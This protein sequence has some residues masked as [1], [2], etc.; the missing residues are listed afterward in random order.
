MHHTFV[1]AL[2]TPVWKP[3][4]PRSA[5][6]TT[7]HRLTELPLVGLPGA[8][9][10]W[11]D[12]SI[13][14]NSTHQWAVVSARAVSRQQRS[15]LEAGCLAGRPA[16]RASG[17]E[18]PRVSR[19]TGQKACHHACG[20]DACALRVPAGRCKAGVLLQCEPRNASGVR[21]DFATGC[22]ARSVQDSNRGVRSGVNLIAWRAE[23]AG[24]LSRMYRAWHACNSWRL[25]TLPRRSALHALWPS[26]NVRPVISH[27]ASV[28]RS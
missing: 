1:R 12:H 24:L 10:G 14:E 4:L 13:A 9:H 23:A 17:Q 15:G 5:G 21:S 18:G 2:L 11:G 3:R 16:T 27:H 25:V 20:A 19:A 28:P 6:Q 26:A 8:S 22:S 7:H